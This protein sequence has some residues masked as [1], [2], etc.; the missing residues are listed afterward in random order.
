MLNITEKSEGEAAKDYVL[1]QL[2]YN[3][4]H[5]NL[6]PGQKL[7][8]PE[9]C[10][11]MNVS[12]NPLREAELELA[13]SKLIEIKPKIGAFVSY[14]NSDIVEQLRDLRCVLEAQLAV[15]ACDILTKNQLDSLYENVALWEMYIKR[16]DEEKIFTLDK[17]F[18]GSLYKMC[19]KTIWYNL[20]ESMAPHFDRTT[21]L[22]FRCKET[23]RILKDHGEL[24]A[25]IE[26][27][28]KEKAAHISQRHM[29]RYS[30]NIDAIRKMFPEYFND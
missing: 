1:R 16:G 24:V 28:D 17:E 27:K 21:I 30:E 7:E 25:A 12:N 3:I 9:L 5:T 18:H 11:L 20:V 2:I 22:S 15:E 14:V 23:G 6:L 29:S 4:V 10:S 26:K 8:A 19:G 13:Q